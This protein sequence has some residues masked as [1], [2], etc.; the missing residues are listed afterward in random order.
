MINPQK[1]NG[2]VPIANEIVNKLCS[3]RISGEE[4]LVLWVILRKTYGWNKKK[5]KISLRQIAEMTGLKPP[6]VVRSLKKL[7][8]RGVIKKD[9]TFINTYLF[10]KH[11]DEWKGVIK[12]DNTL[13]GVIKSDNTSPSNGL[14]KGKLNKSVIKSDNTS[15]KNGL[16]IRKT[17]KSVIKSDNT[18]K[19]LS[20]VIT[21]VIKND[22][23]SVIKSDNYKR[24]KTIDQKT[25]PIQKIFFGEFVQL[26][27]TQYESL[28]EKFSEEIIHEYI[29]RLNLYIGSKGVEYK[30]HY[31]TI[32]AWLRKDKTEKL[33]LNKEIKKLGVIGFVE[34]HSNKFNDDKDCDDFINKFLSNK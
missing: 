20:K 29:E 16:L 22:N 28:V 9:N 5:D 7:L 19:V 11:Y 26:F 23:A 13:L 4:W 25:G 32:L 15:G 31:H 24:H 34:K 6:N 8:H 33:D 21:G 18:P 12:S 10:N 14:P 27:Q 1:E 3:Y 30:S 17:D 2:Y